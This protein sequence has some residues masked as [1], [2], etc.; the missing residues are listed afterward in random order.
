MF[1][2]FV[3]TWNVTVGLTTLYKYTNTQQIILRNR[4]SVQKI[5]NIPNISV[6]TICPESAASTAPEP[7]TLPTR[8]QSPWCHC[9]STTH[10]LNLHTSVHRCLVPSFTPGDL[11][12]DLPACTYLSDPH[13]P[14]SDFSC[15]PPA[16]RSITN[17]ID[18][19][20]ETDK[21]VIHWHYLC[22]DLFTHYSPATFNLQYTCCL[23]I[24]FVA[25]FCFMT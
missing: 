3:R 14:P 23:D 1:W 22:I 2:A 21:T 19:K 13:W 11:P 10:Y 8:S 20:P 4:V 5:L 24:T 16:S 15:P 12:D 7:Y 25:F 9:S 6:L 17:T 18:P